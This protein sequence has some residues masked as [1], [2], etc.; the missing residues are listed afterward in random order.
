MIAHT[1][2]YLHHNNRRR[3]LLSL[4]IRHGKSNPGKSVTTIEYFSLNNQKC[5]VYHPS[6]DGYPTPSSNKIG[7]DRRRQRKL[8][9]AEPAYDMEECNDMKLA[10]LGAILESINNV[11]TDCTDFMLK[12]TRLQCYA[13]SEY[14]EDPEE[15]DSSS[16]DSS[17]PA[18]SGCSVAPNQYQPA[19]KWYGSINVGFDAPSAV[20][21]FAGTTIDPSA[22]DNIWV[23]KN[24][25]TNMVIEGTQLTLTANQTDRW[26]SR[27]NKSRIDFISHDGTDK[28]ESLYSTGFPACNAE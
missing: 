12:P 27:V 15:A 9:W 24:V 3:D 25:F 5:V 6:C 18:D 22:V 26:L 14:E 7:C 23:D 19:S 16:T 17:V 2:A 21:D 11:T 20:V 8:Q 10:A 13:I 1:F 28:L 4:C